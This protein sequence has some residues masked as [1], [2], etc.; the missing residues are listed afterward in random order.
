MPLAQ[1]LLLLLMQPAHP[2]VK[3]LIDHSVEANT[4]SLPLSF[5]VGRSQDLARQA[6]VGR[7]SPENQTNI[8]DHKGLKPNMTESIILDWPKEKSPFN[9]LQRCKWNYRMH[10]KRTISWQIF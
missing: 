10:Q 3:D 8:K 4:H 5:W 9:T 7:S 2:F 1:L 6:G